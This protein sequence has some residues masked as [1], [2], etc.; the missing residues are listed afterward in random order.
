MNSEILLIAVV[1]GII[2]Y[3]IFSRAKVRFHMQGISGISIFLAILI[4]IAAAILFNVIWGDLSDLIKPEKSTYSYSRSI[5]FKLNE[6]LVH[7]LYVLPLLILAIILYVN[8]WKKNIKYRVVVFPYFA[9]T[10]I[11]VIRL[12]IEAGSI[13]IQHFQKGGV[14]GVL[15]FVLA[16]LSFLVFYVQRRM[17][18]HKKEEITQ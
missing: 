9:A 13:A 6:L 10:T 17:E 14:Y 8:T 2:L 7:T 12:L 1:A 4:F 11:M 5:E 18:E 16:T 3:F 15:I